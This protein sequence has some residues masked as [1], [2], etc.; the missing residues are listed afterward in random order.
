LNDSNKTVRIGL[1]IGSV[2]AKYVALFPP[3]TN[4]ADKI[5][6][7]RIESIDQ[8]NHHPEYTLII[9]KVQP[10]LGDPVGT[11]FRLLNDFISVCGDRFQIHLHL[12]G[13]QAKYIAQQL[14][15][16]FIN[17]FKAIS[18]G[19]VEL[20]P[21]ART[22]LEIGGDG[23]RF[24]S[25]AKDPESDQ[26]SILDY[27]R[28]GDCAA[29]T[30]SFIDQQA[31]RLQYSIEEIGP[32]VL[33][34]DTSATIAGRCSVFA[35]SDMVHA[36]QRGYS[37]AAI[38][39]GLC[40]A[41]VRNY[42]GT[43]LRNKSLLPKVVFVGGVAANQGVVQAMHD[44]LGLDREK[45]IIPPH[46][47][48]VAALGSA[49]LGDS[50]PFDPERLKVLGKQETLSGQKSPSSRPLDISRVRYA[51]K[52]AADS[53]RAF[54]DGQLKVYLGIDVGSVSTNL[55][56]LD[57]D[58]KIIDEIY[59]RTEGQPIKVIQREFRRWQKKWAH[60]VTVIGVGTTGSG[61]ELIGQLVGAD[62]IHDEITAHKTGA[63]FIAETLF[64]D[65]VDTIFEI[66]GQD[67]KFISIE[68][69][70]V[71]DFT[72]NEACAAGTGSFL[73]EQ[74]AKMNISIKEEFANLALSSQN[75][76]K[77]GERCTVFMEKDV[78][79]YLQQGIDKRDITA[80][81][82]Y[83]VV[84]NY[85]NRVV[86]GRKIG[87]N[88]YF[89]GGTAYNRAVAAAFAS[90][91]QKPIIVPPHN[92]VMGAI[93]AALLAKE[94][95]T[96]FGSQSRF[97]GFDLTKVEFSIR[98]IQCKACTNQCDVQE[99]TVEGEK[100]YWGDKCSERFR[101][102]RKVKQK[103]VLP[104][105]F[106]IYQN[107]LEKD[108]PSPDGLGVK[109]GIPRTMYFY[110]RFP[111]WRAYFSHLGAEL[112]L[113][114]ATNNEI[115]KKGRELC[116]AEPCFPII[117][118][119][120]HV[121]EFFDRQIDYIFLPNVINAE[122]EFPE[123]ESWYCPW[124]QTLPLVIKNTLKD[125]QLREKILAPVVRF[126]D[127][128]RSVKKSLVP[129]AKSLGVSARKSD[130]AV[131]LAYVAQN[132]FMASLTEAGQQ[133]LPLLEEHRHQAIVIVGR[134]YNVYDFGINL[135]IPNKLRNDYGIN[136]IPMDFL[137]LQGID[138]SDIHENMF[139]NYGKRILQAAKYVGSRTDL[140][141]IY[142]TNFK[143]GPDSY[144]K[145]FVRDAVG[146]PFLVLQFD[147]HG[148]DAGMMTRCEAYLE[149]K[150]MLRESTQ[151]KRINESLLES[152]LK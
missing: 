31:V 20:V 148:N 19:V 10:I 79:A 24:I 51:Q 86:R 120:G 116:I 149:S 151:T 82:A 45:L 107:L 144:I 21:E 80:G 44:I 42:K 36:Q 101:K 57:E 67:S 131:E 58:G 115:V 146:A 97:R 18:R 123:T 108:F 2:S 40:E 49:L 118:A 89:Q 37:P 71:V 111:F 25:V 90:V 99:I 22:I 88:I 143:C 78:T 43:V 122:T 139:W 98:H 16:P 12:T 34:A 27:E 113:T 38:L 128:I 74:A 15:V 32:L 110:D 136:V 61:R 23:S 85:L 35:K 7:H 70:I 95:M 50:E 59:T 69:G 114:D 65:K 84:H 127:G 46:F 76:V 96:Q 17:E 94:K 92:G 26:V 124:G 75:P 119:H 55:V 87:N 130:R 117:V 54:H 140:H 48:H 133:I 138:I 109:I 3:L 83:A 132:Q 13:S 9:S 63:S 30:G 125:A 141:L 112:V 29:G 91:L 41:V 126:R 68:N 14:K 121:K 73:E 4:I 66:G 103:P 105:L 6:K 28:N 8:I 147:G 93:G 72:M 60:Q 39:K 145:H 77:M 106:A 56:L 33:Q 150:G 129:L 64:D 152:R 47:T 142:F 81:L 102:K 53:E 5:D 11:A 1:D 135:N 134:P 62:V 137:P 100:T 104:D 52:G